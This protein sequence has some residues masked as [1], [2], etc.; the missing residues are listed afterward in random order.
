MQNMKPVGYLTLTLL[1]AGIAIPVLA[2][3]SK[4][5]IIEFD[6]PGSAGTEAVQPNNAWVITGEYFIPN[7][8]PANGFLRTPDGTI[9]TFAVPGAY[10]T[11]PYSINAEGEI[12]GYTCNNGLCNGFLRTR[13]GQLTVFVVPGAVSS[14]PGNINTA[15]EI[16]GEYY[17]AS[18]VYHCFLRAPDGTITTFDAPDAGTASGQG[19]YTT[20]A[21]GLSPA[22]AIAG[23]YLDAN[24]VNHGYLRAPDGTIST[25]DVPGAGTGT[26]QGTTVNGINELA[27]IPGTYFDANNVPH[28]YLRYA[29]GKFITFDVPGATGT[30]GNNINAFG[31]INGTYSDANGASHGFV[32]GPGGAIIV[33]DAPDAGT[34][35]GQGTFTNANNAWGEVAGTYYDSNNVAHGFLWK[36]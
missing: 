14:F 23:W 20:A 17:D 19:T 25:F 5:T 12:T 2:Q 26:Y 18:N 35:S 11:W 32:R 28:G 15:G 4:P 13:N 33:F 3:P 30:F 24:N 16:S 6:V 1:A 29:D 10:I 27:E 31:A 9:T 36:P 8:G 21:D 7:G 22:G 34:A